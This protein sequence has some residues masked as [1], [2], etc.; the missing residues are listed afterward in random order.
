MKFADFITEAQEKV[1]KPYR[2]RSL[3]VTH[4]DTYKSSTVFEYAIKA[5]SANIRIEYYPTELKSGYAEDVF[6]TGVIKCTIETNGSYIS[7]V[8]KKLNEFLI[9]YF[10]ENNFSE[11]VAK[12]IKNTNALILSQARELGKSDKKRGPIGKK[13]IALQRY[14]VDQ[15]RIDYL[16]DQR[17]KYDLKYLPVFKPTVKGNEK[18]GHDLVLLKKVEDIILESL[19]ELFEGKEKQ[20][21]S[22]MDEAG[23]S[24]DLSKAKR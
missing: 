12:K 7:T 1:K 11:N 5:I 14:I 19:K 15:D 16:E 8:N 22:K 3:K 21:L 20:I 24:E 9:G 13:L 18:H 23:V 17:V 10:K 4:I 2:P 6:D